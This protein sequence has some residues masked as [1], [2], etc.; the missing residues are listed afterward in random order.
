MFETVLV[1]NRGE[2]AV[3][4]IR[5]LKAMGVRSVAVH[6]D[7]DHGAPHVA[8][9]DIAVR[10]PGDKPADT[11]LRADLILKAAVEH[12]AQAVIPG[13]GFL[14]E[15]SDFAEDCAKAGIVFVGPTPDQIR[16]FGMKHASREL[17][18]AAGVP[19]T[20]GSGLLSDLD[21]ALEAA[22]RVGYPVMLKSTAGGG[23]IGMTRCADAQALAGSFETVRRQAL[24]FFK[25][26]GVFLERCIDE[27]RHVEVQIFGDGR[28]KVVALGERDCS[29]QRRNQKVVE[30]TPAPDLPA[31]TRAKMLAAAQNLGASVGYASA[32]TVEFIYDRARDAFYF[33][34]VNARL[35]VEHP[36]TE[37]VLGVDLVEWMI[38]TA[39]GDPPDLT[40]LPEPAGAAIEVRVYAE[41]PLHGFQPSAGE[42]TEVTFPEDV[43][44]DAWVSTG[45]FVSP[46]YDPMIAKLIVHGATRAEAIEKLKRA[47]DASR[48][49]G[50]ATNLGY[51]RAIAESGDF[52]SGDVSTRT[53]DRLDYA[54]R[55]VEVVAPGAYTTI[56]D[57]PGRTGLWHIGVPPSGPMDDYAFRLANRIVGN[58]PDAAGVECTLSGPTLKF[59]ADSVVALT[60]ASAEATLDGEPVAWWAPVSV[61][62]GQVLSVGKTLTGCRTYLAVAGGLDVP[63][64]LGSRSTFVLGKFG[65]HG[66]R[67]LQKGDVVPIGLHVPLAAAPAPAALT[68]SYGRH[69]TVGVLYGPHGAPDFFTSEAVETF[70]ATDWEVHYNSNRLGIRLI[71][72]K[73]SWARSDGG[74]AGLHPSNIHDTEYAIGAINFTG[75]MPVILTRDGPSLGGFVCPATI[76]K[77]ELWKIG[78][79]KPGDT[80]RFEPMTFD[81]ALALE[82]A[83]DAAIADLSPP[84]KS[85]ARA[86]PS[87]APA[88]TVSAAVIAESPA[89]GDRPAVAYR[90][91]GDRYVLLE[92]GPNELDL[93]YRFRVHALMEALE[94]D[95]VDGVL[96]LSPGVRSLQINYDGRVI[97]QRDLIDRLIEIE[98]RLPEIAKMKVKTRVLHLP[99]AFEDSAT[100][101][102]QTRYRET[103][104]ANAPWMPNNVDFIQ[105]I[106]GLPSREDV[107][108]TAF[109]ASYMVLGLG[110][111]YLGAPCAVPIDPRHRL[112]TSKY[113]PARTFTAEGTVGIG[114]V[115]MCIYGMDSPGGYQLIGRTVPIWN[116]FTRNPV[117]TPGEP[118]LLRFFD[119]VR[120]YE[121]TEPE[122]D[123]LRDEF[124]EGRATVR[125]EEE[126]FDLGAYHA[127]LEAE[128]DSIAAFKANQQRAFSAEVAR[129]NEEQSVAALDEE[130]PLDQADV[131]G[132]LVLAEL[133]GSVWKV[134]VEEGQMVSIGETVVILEAMKTEIHIAAPSSGKVERVF[135]RSG[136]TVATGEKLLAIAI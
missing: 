65:G 55:A 1:A 115:Y 114:G 62:A 23:G 127:F 25:D 30:E 70:F 87:L 95:P 40:R 7:A 112:L 33:L 98:E 76:A 103:V 45:S 120:F 6:S 123:G 75:D 104:R 46:F 19:L 94:A 88:A 102:A 41:D 22:G 28:G 43:R 27:G 52:A 128:G 92:Y 32:G 11:Y 78:Q 109:E 2:I 29:L 119:Q 53:L 132:D 66:G 14:S 71:G 134:L 58:A 101:D 59:H 48:I 17:A 61:R 13:Y 8:M 84:A 67:V 49:G 39:A 77:A 97:H 121:V 60:G 69:W 63:L 44:V 26:S 81:D 129:W 122:L 133:H 100:L 42:L 64:Y 85:P 111:V 31:A 110:D 107:K 135:A 73:P 113:N 56:Q 82:R 83:Q 108:K 105:R 136:R 5:T 89:K 96:E 130:A 21:E 118:W 9:A 47:L 3:R 86:V 18:E 90:Q 20:P 74:E 125:I 38:L 126:V 12:G 50:V 91:A 131:A 99:M 37:A 116:K 54:P 15:N 51:L 24:N 80:I 16:R 93:R 124:R 34:E 57:Y 72:P 4:I 79:A 35:Q 68:P 106:N 36:V 10:L 117:F